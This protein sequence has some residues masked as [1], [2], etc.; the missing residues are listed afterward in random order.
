MFAINKIFIAI[1]VLFII[2]IS[3]EV[4][5]KEKTTDLCYKCHE[6][7][8]ESSSKPYLHFPF[9]QGSCFSCH[10]IHA[11]KNKSLIKTEI[12]SLCLSCHNS[13]K[14]SLESKY[15]HS[16][17]NRGKCTDCHHAHASENSHL[18]VRKAEEI[19]WNCHTSLK[20]VANK[21]YIHDPFNNKKC[22][23]CHKPHASSQESHIIDDPKILC[24]KCHPANCKINN[25]SIKSY[26]EKMNCL[27]CHASHSSDFA[28]LLGPYGHNAFLEKKCE[29]CHETISSNKITLKTKDKNLCFNC[30]EKNN[31]KLKEG[32]I[33]L[34]KGCVICH[35]PH[36][37]KEKGLVIKKSQLCLSCHENVEKKIILM[38]KI[39]KTKPPKCLPVKHRK[40]LDCHIPP[41]SINTLYLDPIKACTKCHEAQHK[42]THP[43]GS[44]AID[45]RNG[46]PMS[47]VTCHSMHSS[48]AEFMLYFDRKKQLCI[49]CHKK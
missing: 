6:Q 30:H 25:I 1:F 46:K 27:Y 9:K 13:I 40:C 35:S 44:E 14:K 15:I 5:A 41:H 10:D 39:L 28:G 23:F 38:E 17:I 18:L 34:E 3:S 19:C 32:D 7:L 29:Q 48:K 21:K 42:I 20:E 4:I 49:Q 16:A 11:G 45:P 43:I 31:L 8:K 2:N 33:H 12:N 22:L 36:A 24:K 47:C 37:S 26:T